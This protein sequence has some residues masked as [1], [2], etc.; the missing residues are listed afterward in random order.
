MIIFADDIANKHFTELQQKYTHAI[1][2]GSVR[3]LD[4][5]LV[6]FTNSARV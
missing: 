2:C 3:S 1:D 5:S 6:L 4:Y